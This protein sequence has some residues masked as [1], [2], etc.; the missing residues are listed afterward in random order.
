MATMIVDVQ[1]LQLDEDR[2]FVYP[3][4]PITVLIKTRSAQ[5]KTFLENIFPV[6]Y[7]LTEARYPRIAV[8]PRDD[9][10]VRTER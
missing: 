2:N 1:I 9:S 10:L 8:D 5:E 6:Q 4:T 7:K 3:E